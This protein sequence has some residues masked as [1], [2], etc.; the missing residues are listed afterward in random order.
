M[1]LF[2]AIVGWVLVGALTFYVW[3]LQSLLGMAMRGLDESRNIAF[4]LAEGWQDTLDALKELEE[5]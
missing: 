5:Q 3:H 1:I 4:E 2:L